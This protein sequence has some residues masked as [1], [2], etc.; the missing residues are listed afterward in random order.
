MLEVYIPFCAEPDDR[1]AIDVYLA[2]GKRALDEA[3]AEMRECLLIERADLPGRPLFFYAA[4]TVWHT[5]PE[6]AHLVLQ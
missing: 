2:E 6:W 1:F 3:G 4:D 5:R